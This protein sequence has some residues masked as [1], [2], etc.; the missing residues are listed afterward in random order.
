MNFEN[1]RVKI[2]FFHNPLL[3][4]YFHMPLGAVLFMNKAFP[5]YKFPFTVILPSLYL[6]TKVIKRLRHYCRI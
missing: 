3:Y 2:F 1:P 6:H 5:L 4:Y